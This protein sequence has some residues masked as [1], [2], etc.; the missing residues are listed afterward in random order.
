[1]IDKIFSMLTDRNVAI[2]CAVS[3]LINM[4]FLYL[5]YITVVALYPLSNG[6]ITGGLCY[7]TA[8]AVGILLS[9]IFKL[10][11]SIVA[12]YSN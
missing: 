2:L 3:I 5:V 11:A 10:A 6:M 12:Y 4:A 7:I 8:M 1:M 9:N